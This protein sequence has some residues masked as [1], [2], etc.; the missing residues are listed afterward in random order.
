MSYSRNF[1]AVVLLCAASI[2]TALAQ[3]QQTPST[4][5]ETSTDKK[6]AAGEATPTPAP[7]KIRVSSGVADGLLKKKV[8]PGYPWKA[9]VKGIQGDVVLDIVIATDG[10]I[11]KMAVVSGDPL[12]TTA[13]V[14]AVKKWVYTPYMLDGK[15]VEVETAVKISFRM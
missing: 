13:A 2:L 15:P 14:N 9:R 4:T 8:A 5:G 7:K 3:N 11:T 1:F 10:R 12:L 6:P